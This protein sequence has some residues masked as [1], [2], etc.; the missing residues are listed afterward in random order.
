MKGGG[1]EFL[2]R[3]IETN[4]FFNRIKKKDGFTIVLKTLY[5]KNLISTILYKSFNNNNNKPVA[6]FKKQPLL[7]F[8]KNFP[9]L[10]K[11]KF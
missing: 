7:N 8:I 6:I 11:T 2:K 5:Y 1:V 10:P 3:M 9:N 4:H